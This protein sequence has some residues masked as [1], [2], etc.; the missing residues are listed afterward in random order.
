MAGLSPGLRIDG[1][2]EFMAHEPL[3]ADALRAM[4]LSLL[5]DEQQAR[6]G[7]AR[8]VS[9][10][11][12]IPDLGRFRIALYYQR[13]H[14]E[15]SVRV[16]PPQVRRLEDMGLPPIVRDLA[17]RN[18]G[19][20]LVTGPT[21]AGKTTLMNA[22]VDAINC[23]RRARI[24]T[25]EDPIEYVHTNK[26]SVV[27]QREVESD[28]PSFPAALHAALRQDPN[29]ICV[30]E[31]RNLETVAT[32]LTA[33]ETGH[34]VLATLHTQGAWQTIE[35]IV[36]V[37]PTAQH[38]QVRTQLANCLQG[39]VSLH[40]LPR[41]GEPGRVLAYEILMATGGIKNIIRSGKLEQL[42]Q[43][44]QTGGEDGMNT[45]D[46]CLRQFYEQGLISYDTALSRAQNP[47]EFR[48]LR[49]TALVRA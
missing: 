24:V 34:L 31:M 44:M 14:L 39:V 21:G 38:N 27:I 49:T 30:G 20:V 33:A 4:L 2:I 15:A 17:T 3:P 37:F 28:T 5:S 25:I 32:A 8:D 42:S 41:M 36:D 12:T 11:I 43:F 13:G 16:V 9:L 18:S 46:R 47:A 23:E 35:R 7:Q 40:L 45:M 29:V 6:L 19:L 10:S 1:D 22:L 48:S 26:R